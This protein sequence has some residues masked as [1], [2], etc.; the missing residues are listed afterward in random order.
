MVPTGFVF[1][2]MPYYSANGREIFE[3]GGNGWAYANPYDRGAPIIYFHWLPWLLGFGIKILHVDPGLQFVILGLIF[4]LLMSRLTYAVV[5]TILPKQD[6]RDLLF[7]LV[8][9]GGGILS[10]AAVLMNL[11][12]GDPWWEKLLQFDPGGGLWFLNW[13]RNLVFGTEALYHFLVAGIW[14]SL[15]KGKWGYATLGGLALATTHPF[16]SG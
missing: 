5:E 10:L 14:L 8:M 9:W 1:Y 3:A 15:I 6:F 12:H 11:V 2:D 4:G 16:S 7:L 13:G